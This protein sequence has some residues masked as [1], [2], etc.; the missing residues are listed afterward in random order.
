[1]MQ[2]SEE[3]ISTENK[4]G[5]ARQAFNDAVT[6]F[7]TTREAFPSNLIAGQFGFTTAEL[8]AEVAP[9][10]KAAPRVTF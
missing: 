10:V 4:V 9:E 3:P 8:L 1:M 2:L 5:F 7:N 6:L